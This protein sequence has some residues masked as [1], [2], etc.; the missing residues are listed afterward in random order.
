M[1]ITLEN[2]YTLQTT[3]WNDFTIADAFGLTA[4]RDTFNRSFRDWKFNK[5]YVTELCLVM[6]WKIWQ[7]YHAGNDDLASLYNELWMEV[8]GWCMDNLKDD[9]LKYFLET[10]D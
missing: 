5:I 1:G 4:V 7:H 8:D 2:G 10:T 9:D 3:F 6:N